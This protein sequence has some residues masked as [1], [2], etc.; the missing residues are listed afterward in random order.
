MATIEPYETKKGK[1]YRVRYRRPD[2]R[3]TDKSGFRTKRDATLWANSLEV[4]KAHGNYIDPAAGKVT[5]RELGEAWL[6]RQADW[7]PSYRY[8]MESTWS[9][10]VL[11]RWGDYPVSKIT[12]TELQQWIADMNRS[13]SV[14]SRCVTILS[15]ILDDAVADQLIHSN[16]A[17]NIAL[18]RSDKKPRVYLDHQQVEDFATAA[19]DNG[20]I[21]RTL[22]YTGLRWGELAGLHGPD[23]DT[24]GHRISVNRNAVQVGSKIVVGTPKT[25]ELRTVPIPGFLATA[26]RSRIGEGIVF[27]TRAG[28][29]ARAPRASETK[30]SWWRT[31]MLEAGI[32][33]VTPHSLRHTAASLAIQAG[34]HVVAV[35]KMLGHANASMT[36]SVYSHLFD[37]DLESVAVALEDRRSEV[38]AK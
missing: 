15:S 37:T 22:A 25:H 9:T 38:L 31:A 21:I 1:R 32:P 17:S 6:K 12:R 4:S 7:K 20:L 35:Q 29:Y 19:G 18:P 5:V 30:R 2:G 27:P 14:T 3:S 26:L 23:V 36:L 24:V 33:E 11:P 10:H 13:R 28:G 8:T 16:R 34:A